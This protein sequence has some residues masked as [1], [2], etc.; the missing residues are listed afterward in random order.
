VRVLMWAVMWIGSRHCYRS[1][2]ISID[3]CKFGCS[4][5]RVGVSRRRCGKVDAAIRER[6][7][8]TKLTGILVSLYL[9]AV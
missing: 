4:E 3:G 6:Q 8:C 9:L 1:H 5:T 2:Q 7:P